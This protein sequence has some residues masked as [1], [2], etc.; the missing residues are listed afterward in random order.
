MRVKTFRIKKMNKMSTINE[1]SEITTL[2]HRL[3]WLRRDAIKILAKLDQSESLLEVEE[4][5]EEEK[6]LATSEE[7][8]IFDFIRSL[9][10]IA[11]YLRPE[12]FEETRNSLTEYWKDMVCEDDGEDCEMEFSA[13]Q[14]RG[15]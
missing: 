1:N 5:L 4:I 14:Q 3:S 6:W 15:I 10:L 2:D 13:S 9:A 8:K 7:Y 12:T 11:T